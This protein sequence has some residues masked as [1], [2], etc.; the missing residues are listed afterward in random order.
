MNTNV[1]ER[2]NKER[3]MNTVTG[4]ICNKVSIINTFLQSKV[5]LQSIR[6]IFAQGKTFT[7]NHF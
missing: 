7:D 4:K 3:T 1:T 6:L 2:G 5:K